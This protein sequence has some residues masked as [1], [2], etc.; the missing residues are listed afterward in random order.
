MMLIN[1]NKQVYDHHKNPKIDDEDK[2][3]DDDLG[4][5]SDSAEKDAGERSGVQGPRTHR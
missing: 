1:I 4:E 3:D 2:T 5:G